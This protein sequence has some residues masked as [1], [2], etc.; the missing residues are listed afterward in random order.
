MKYDYNEVLE[1]NNPAS[2]FKLVAPPVWK[3]SHDILE[4]LRLGMYKSSNM[5]YNIISRNPEFN[6]Y[7]FGQSINKQ[8]TLSNEVENI[9]NLIDTY[10]S[11]FMLS[12][13]DT[14]TLSA[15]GDLET[16]QFQTLYQS[17]GIARYSSLFSQS[18]DIKVPMNIGLSVGD[19]L[20]QLF[21][22]K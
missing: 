3:Q 4:K 19:Y 22:D 2:N 10:S 18:L 13:V 1:P 14:G 8:L 6:D 20:L 16:P 21:K 9:P 5:F 17:Q 12:V 11:R 7:Y 15:K